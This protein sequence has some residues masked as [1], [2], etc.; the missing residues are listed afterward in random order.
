MEFHEI[1]AAEISVTDFSKTICCACA[2]STMPRDKL[3]GTALSRLSINKCP[4][5]PQS[6][7]ALRGRVRPEGRSQHGG[8]AAV[9]KSLRNKGNVAE[10]LAIISFLDVE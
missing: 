4:S 7:V 9:A 10:A 5:V 2:M 8:S 1:S 3:K 6:A